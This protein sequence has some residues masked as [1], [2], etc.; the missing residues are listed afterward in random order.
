[1]VELTFAQL[2]TAFVAAVCLH[3][4]E[5]AW[6]M[7][8][9]LRQVFGSRPP[10]GAWEFRFATGVLSLLLVPLAVLAVRAGPGSAAAHVWLGVVFAMGVNAI[11]PHLAATVALRRY[12]PGTA[13]GL[14]LNLP[15]AV[16]LCR[17]GLAARWV[18]PHTFAWAA[19]TVA[20]ALLACVPALFALG[21]RLAPPLNSAA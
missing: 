3:N 19:P 13:T 6:L 21:R 2:C 11:L 20:V 8:R 12:M 4:L 17:R 15:L 18:E 7:P 16:S 10:V 14:L 9:W 1:M 5:E